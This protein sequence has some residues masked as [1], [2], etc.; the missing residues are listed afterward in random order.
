MERLPSWLRGTIITDAVL[1]HA[2]RS[3]C[4]SGKGKAWDLVSIKLTGI[5]SAHKTA[6]T[7]YPKI[8]GFR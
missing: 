7:V 1:A 6:K 4:R 8:D 3:P 2:P 5:P